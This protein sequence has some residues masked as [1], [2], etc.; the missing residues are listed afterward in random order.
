MVQTSISY[1]FKI[2]T[3]AVIILAMIHMVT[4]M[5]QQ[6]VCATSTVVGATQVLALSLKEEIGRTPVATNVDWT[7]VEQEFNGVTMVLVPAG[8]FMMGGA[9]GSTN[10][11]P[12]HKQHF[13]TPFWIDKTEV[14]R[15]QYQACVAAG[16]CE[17][18]PISDYSTED[19]Q[20]INHVMWDQAQIYCAWR[21]ARLPTEAEWEYAAR[22][23]DGLVYPWGNEYDGSKVIGWD[24]PTYSY[25]STAPVGS[26]P[27]G[28]SWVGA[29]DI[30]GNVLEWVS[31]LY[32]DYP[33]KA[34][35][36]RELSE[37][38]AVH[39]LRGGSFVNSTFIL[40]GAYRYL[41]YPKH[42]YYNYG[43]RCARSF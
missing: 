1:N 8:C 2:L 28:Q 31:S 14:T 25:K 29:L 39:V 10:E 26:R 34:D 18:T 11:H 15:A 37:G 40:R 36:G 30:S 6:S 22:G 23:P 24:D 41:N 21:D 33:Y 4:L 19:D 5:I 3:T 12:V 32:K 7:P 35:D 9:E 27:D 42:D 20:P 17:E 13:D 38:M 16:V 43:F